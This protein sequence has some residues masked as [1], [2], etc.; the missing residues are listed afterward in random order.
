MK[1][2][3]Y[4]G[5][6]P[7]AT[8]VGCAA[9]APEPQRSYIAFPEGAPNTFL[10][11]AEFWGRDSGSTR[12]GVRAS[13]ARS[14][15]VVIVGFWGDGETRRVS[16]SAARYPRI[17][18]STARFYLGGGYVQFSVSYGETR[19]CFRNY[20]GRNRILVQFTSE[21]DVRAYDESFENCT[22]TRRAIDQQ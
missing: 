15:D 11:E 2:T 5:I 13:R 3:L 16:L 14:G 10:E 18:L 4:A 17:D 12:I 21:L 8:L 22:G 20:D 19:R 7:L 1:R 6:L 9:A